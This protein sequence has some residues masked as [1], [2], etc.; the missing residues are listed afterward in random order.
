MSETTIVIVLLGGI[1][2]VLWETYRAQ[3][4]HYKWLMDCA[5]RQMDRR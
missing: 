5:D 1:L 4:R 2:G 3:L